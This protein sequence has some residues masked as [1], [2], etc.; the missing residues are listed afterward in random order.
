MR[1][2]WALLLPIALLLSVFAL[3]GL[4]SNASAQSVTLGPGETQSARY[5]A[6]DGDSIAYHWTASESIT[7]TISDPSG[8]IIVDTSAAQRSGIREVTQTGDYMLVWT[9]LHATSVTLTY[10]VTVLPFHAGGLPL[11]GFVA[12][13]LIAIIIIVVVVLV[14]MVAFRSDRARSEDIYRQQQQYYTGPQLF[15]PTPEGRCSRC[16]AQVKTDG[17]YCENCGARLR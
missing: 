2:E 1:K 15:P 11:L 3:A 10:E 16:G 9:N 17:A 4:A 7:F 14:I 6:N 5:A 13:L 12:V 8:D